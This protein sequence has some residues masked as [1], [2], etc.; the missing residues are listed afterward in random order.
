MTDK[1]NYRSISLRNHTYSKL[2]ALSS[3]L[4]PG[5]KLS[6]A[7]TVDKLVTDKFNGSRKDVVDD[8]K[9]AISEKVYKRIVDEVLDR[10]RKSGM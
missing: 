8:L 1:F 2:E 9:G 3:T 6:R 7:K 5:V 4:I 10:L